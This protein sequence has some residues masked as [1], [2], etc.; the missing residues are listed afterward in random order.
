MK[1]HSSGYIFLRRFFLNLCIISKLLHDF[2]NEI[3]MSQTGAHSTKICS[4]HSAALHMHTHR[5]SHTLFKASLDAIEGL[6]TEA[7]QALT[8]LG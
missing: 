2:T 4:F 5:H 3:C 8:L 7:P 6:G 1:M